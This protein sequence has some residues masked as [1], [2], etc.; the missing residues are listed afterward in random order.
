MAQ[1]IT[2]NFEAFRLAAA[3]ETKDFMRF[4][5]TYDTYCKRSRTHS[6][7]ECDIVLKRAQEQMEALEAKCGFKIVESTNPLTWREFGAVCEAIDRFASG[8]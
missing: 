5:K 7:E 3:I 6:D 4:A 1:N 8:C 2:V